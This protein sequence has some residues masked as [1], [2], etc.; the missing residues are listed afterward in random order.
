MRITSLKKG[1]I[2]QITT[3]LVHK[4]ILMPQTMKIPD[5][6][7]TVDKEEDKKKV[8]IAT[9]MDICYLKIAELE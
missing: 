4:F 8:H 1:S 3:T 5:A 9:L 7:A 6:K 2:Q